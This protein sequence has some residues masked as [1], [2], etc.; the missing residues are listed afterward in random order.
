MDRK[1][2]NDYDDDDEDDDDI[3]IELNPIKRFIPHYT[4]IM[5]QAGGIVDGIPT[6]LLDAYPQVFMSLPL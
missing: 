1:L 5:L 6:D 4:M 3:L 2:N